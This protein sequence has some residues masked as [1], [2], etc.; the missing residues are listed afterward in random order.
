[1]NEDERKYLESIYNDCVKEELEGV[2]SVY[3]AG[4]GDLCIDLL[5]KDRELF[6]PGTHPRK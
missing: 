2:L 1:M 3:G 6:R 5:N 4:Q